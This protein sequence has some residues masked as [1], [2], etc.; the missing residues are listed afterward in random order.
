VLCSTLP[1]VSDN[2]PRRHYLQMER[3]SYSF[4]EFQAHFASDP[5]VATRVWNEAEPALADWPCEPARKVLERNGLVVLCTAPRYA[6]DSLEAP[7][8]AAGIV[9]CAGRPGDALSP[10]GEDTWLVRWLAK[11][12]GAVKALA[13]CAAQP[14][15][16]T[17]VFA[18]AQV[19][20]FGSEQDLAQACLVLSRASA[21]TACS[22]H[23]CLDA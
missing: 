8:C 18:K 16:V 21:Y 15:A 5:D 17:L 22:R 12:Y 7:C 13:Q 1:P 14:P 6:V 3:K 10:L 20:G 9:V 2:L 19:E 23:E 4:G 11:V